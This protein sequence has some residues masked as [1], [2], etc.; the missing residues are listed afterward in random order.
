MSKTNIELVDYCKA[1]LG[2]PYWFGTY[3]QIGNIAV[4][5]A[6]SKQY[7][8]YYSDARKQKAKARGDFGCKVHDCAGLI[9]GYTMLKE[10]LPYTSPTDYVSRLDLS[11]DAMYSQASEKGDIS[12]IPEIIGLGVHRKGHIGVYIGNGKVIEAKGF[13]YGVITSDLKGSTFKHWLKIPHIEYID[14]DT[15]KIN[16]FV[17]RLYVNCLGRNSDEEGKNAWVNILITGKATGSE[18]A[19]GFFYS[20]EFL[21]L[22]VPNDVYLRK[23]YLTFLDRM[24]DKDGFNAW[25]RLLDNGRSRLEIFEGFAKSREFENIC[26]KYGIRP[27]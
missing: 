11:A 18:V 7:P 20:R 3:G 9:K 6:K 25:I 23:L 1:Q 17:E 27:Y 24:P 16:E 15:A 22:N 13:D 14:K 10:G 5:T 12:T 19:Y 21:N 8:N 26:N 2:N 4:W